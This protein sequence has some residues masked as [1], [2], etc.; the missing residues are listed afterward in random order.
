VSSRGVVAVLAHSRGCRPQKSTHPAGGR[1][2]LEARTWAS[3]S[4]PATAGSAFKPLAAIAA[5]NAVLDLNSRVWRSPRQPCHVSSDATSASP[6]SDTAS[7]GPPERHWKTPPWAYP[8]QIVTRAARSSLRKGKQDTRGATMAPN[9]L[10]WRRT[11]K[12]RN[13]DLR[14]A[15]EQTNTR[16]GN[17][18]ADACGWSREK[19]HS[20][21]RKSR[22]IE[23]ST[24]R[25]LRI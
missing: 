1:V 12:G 4:G 8:C 18:D 17:I 24:V 22:L 2:T 3:R 13:R 15:S 10:C 6:H 23:G 7:C 20:M 16:H 9:P 21:S 11:E 14:S 25:P 5:I 19:R